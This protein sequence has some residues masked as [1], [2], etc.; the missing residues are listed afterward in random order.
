VSFAEIWVRNTFSVEAVRVTEENMRKVANWC[1]GRIYGQQNLNESVKLYVQF[2]AVGY[3]KHY[4]AKAFVGD[5][6]IRVDGHFKHY[7]DNAFRRAYQPKTDK[8][9]EVFELVAAA[10]GKHDE[11]CCSNCYGKSGLPSNE[12]LSEEAAKEIVKLFEGEETK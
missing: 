3:S 9:K 11:Y 8:L 2:D 6:V 10:F 7:T 5:W 12:Q 4:A 1:D